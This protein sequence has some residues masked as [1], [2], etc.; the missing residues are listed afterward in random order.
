MKN[1]QDFKLNKYPPY[2]YNIQAQQN[3]SNGKR[4]NLINN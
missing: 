1:N 2:N 3:K 4:L